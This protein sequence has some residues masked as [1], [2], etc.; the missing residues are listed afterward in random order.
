MLDAQPI[1]DTVK[2]VCHH[3]HDPLRPQI[4][5]QIKHVVPALLDV[6]M[7]AL[8]DIQRQYVQ[9]ASIL[10]EIGGNL[11]ADKGVRQMGD[12][13]SALDPVMIRNRHVCHATRKG[14]SVNILRLCEAFRATDFFQYPGRRPLGVFGMNMKVNTHWRFLFYNIRCR[15]SS[16]HQFA[17]NYFAVKAK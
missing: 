2:G 11:F 17:L 14:N 6:G 13:Q 10:G 16:F 1:I 7:L 8:G 15:G 9:L 4:V 12:C 3:V 5:H